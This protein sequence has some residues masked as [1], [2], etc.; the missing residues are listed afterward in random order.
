MNGDNFNTH[1]DD[2]AFRVFIDEVDRTLSRI[3]VGLALLAV[4][5]LACMAAVTP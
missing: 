5:G 4:L 1:A 3:G 2:D